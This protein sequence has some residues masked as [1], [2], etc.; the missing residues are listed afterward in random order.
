MAV[1]RASTALRFSRASIV[2]AA[3][4]RTKSQCPR[5]ERA[6]TQSRESSAGR[7]SWLKRSSAVWIQLEIDSWARARA[8]S[9][10]RRRC[11]ATASP[12]KTQLT[13]PSREI[14]RKAAWRGPIRNRGPTAR[15]RDP[16][17]R[18]TLHPGSLS[19]ESEEPNSSIRALD[20]AGASRA[21]RDNLGSQAA[22]AI[23][24][25]VDFEQF[26]HTCR[27]GRAQ[28]ED[29]APPGPSRDSAC[30]SQACSC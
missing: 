2:G 16:K 1:K 30:R 19:T 4:S 6:S 10:S 21:D 7:R 29:Q 14:S 27:A 28:V 26:M 12:R 5:S 22:K 11:F 24:I 9:P 13:R 3:R 18:A 17:A 15:L 23:E 20:T 25:G 8:S